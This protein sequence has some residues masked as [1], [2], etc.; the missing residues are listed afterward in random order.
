MIRV[1]RMKNPVLSIRP[2][3]LRRNV[4][5]ARNVLIFAQCRIN[6]SSS[7]KI[8]QRWSY[9]EHW[10]SRQLQRDRRDEAMQNSHKR[11][12]GVGDYR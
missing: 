6:G 5:P 10:A 3:S 12:A 4:L 1:E 11:F 8:I 2:E 7:M 9:V